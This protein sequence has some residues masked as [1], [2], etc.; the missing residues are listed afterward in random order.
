MEEK[1]FIFF[2]KVSKKV[3][4]WHCIVLKNYYFIIII[5]HSE[6]LFYKLF[7]KMLATLHLN[8]RRSTTNI[9]S[10]LFN[11][12]IVLAVSNAVSSGRS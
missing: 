3:M 9:L 8:S 1:T 7:K 5:F 12:F 6:Y 2:C 10:P 4:Q 11:A